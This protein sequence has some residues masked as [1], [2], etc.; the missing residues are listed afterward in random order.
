VQV[1]Q[2]SGLLQVD[3]KTS[4]RKQAIQALQG[5]ADV[6]QWTPAVSGGFVNPKVK[7]NTNKEEANNKKKGASGRA[8][9]DSRC[10]Y[11]IVCVCTIHCVSVCMFM[12]NT[13]CVC[14]CMYNSA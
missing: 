14:V 13:L 5:L 3:N 8:A 11:T 9:M 7:K 2:Y 10:V 6:P 4:Q 1:K 12:Y